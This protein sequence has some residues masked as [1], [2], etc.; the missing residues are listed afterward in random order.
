MIICYSVRGGHLEAYSECL[1]MV[2]AVIIV[3]E[4]LADDD[5]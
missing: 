2:V 4:M 1:E 3:A 5:V